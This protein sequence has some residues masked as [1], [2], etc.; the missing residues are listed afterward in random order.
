MKIK[1]YSYKTQ[2][3]Y[4]P[5]ALNTVAEQSVLRTKTFLHV[6]GGIASVNQLNF[7][8]Q[9]SNNMNTRS[10]NIK[11]PSIRNKKRFPT[12]VQT[13]KMKMNLKRKEN[14]ISTNN[15]ISNYVYPI[16]DFFTIEV[17]GL[18]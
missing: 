16:N 7:H 15:I 2:M 6:T 11:K 14:L 4:T 9:P 17:H 18:C 10:N 13:K 8:Q 5:L 1:L 12:I 3:A